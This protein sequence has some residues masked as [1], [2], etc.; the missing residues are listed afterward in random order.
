MNFS[1]SKGYHIHVSTPGILKLGRDERREI[2]DHVTGTGLDLG[3]DSRWRERIVKLVKRAGVKELKEI[4]GVGEN[5]AG[6]IMEKKENIIRQLKKGVLEGVEGVRE[7][8][9]RSIGEGMAVKLTGDADK[10]VTIDTSRLI[11][12]PNSLH[13]TSGLAAMKTK[14][15]EGFDP[16]NDAVAFPDNPVKVK[17]TKNTKSFEMKDQTHGPYDKDETLEL[18]GYAG[19]YLML[20]DY[21]EF[22]G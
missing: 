21:A 8:T 7:K 12:L 22:V 20:K 15:L 10:M 17:V 6:K 1:G 18:P 3:L 9:I 2:I 19:I 16:L 13:G 14:D 4:E 5:T 11:R